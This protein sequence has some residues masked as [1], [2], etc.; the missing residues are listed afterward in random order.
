MTILRI[1]SIE[2]IVPSPSFDSESSAEIKDILDS[3]T[4]LVDVM[5]AGIAGHIAQLKQFSSLASETLEFIEALARLGSGPDELYLSSSP[6]EREE[7][8]WPV[9]SPSLDFSEGTKHPI[10][11]TV[12]FDKVVGVYLWERDSGPSDDDLLGTLVVNDIE[13]QNFGTNNKSKLM[14]AYVG[15]PKEPSLYFVEYTLEDIGSSSSALQVDLADL[16]SMTAI[17]TVPASSS[18]FAIKRDRKV[19]S[20]YYDPRVENP[21]WSGWFELGGSVAPETTSIAAVSSLPGAT[22]LFVVGL[23]GRIWS[24]YFDPRI[25][26]ANW[27]DWFSLGDNTFPQTSM[28]TAISGVPAGVALFV[29]GHDRKVW[30]QYYDPRVETPAWSGWFPL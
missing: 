19:W 3:A 4:K 11:I 12:P 16:L 6:I 10:N 2:C 1:V 13:I 23:D 22:S 27:S 20:Q 30:S 25:A 8:I 17:S 24:K 26:D 5:P 14:G 7:M 21:A 18:L 28:V 15:N 29:I 9:G